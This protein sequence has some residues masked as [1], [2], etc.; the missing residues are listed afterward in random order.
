MR[1]RKSFEAPSAEPVSTT[2][3][4]TQATLFVK[5]EE[6]PTNIRSI[7]LTKWL[8]QGIDEW[9]WA[10]AAQLRVFLQGSSVTTS[11]VTRSATISRRTA[12][13]SGFNA[14]GL[15]PGLLRG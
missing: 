4:D 5:F 12:I 3:I 8:D 13:C 10:S 9:I 11:T 15:P 2:A 1:R 7:D 14:G 6:N